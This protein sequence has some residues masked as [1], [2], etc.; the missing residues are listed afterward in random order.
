MS[1]NCQQGFPENACADDVFVKVKNFSPVECGQIP[2]PCPPQKLIKVPVKVAIV[3]VTEPLKDSIY[4]CGGFEEVKQIQRSVI[5]TQCHVTEK[6]LY[7]EGYITKNVGYVVPRVNKHKGCE[8][9]C[10]VIKNRYK[11]LTAKLDF[12]FTIPVKLEG[13]CNLYNYPVDEGSFFVDCMKQCDNGYCGELN[14]ERF[15]KQTV[16]LNEPFKYELEKYTIAESVILKKENCETK[17]SYDTIVE[18]LE[19]SLV[20]SIL[21]NQQIAINVATI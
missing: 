13:V 16:I 1:N 20:V 5:L 12:Y 10:K 15:Y 11:D 3:D 14:C 17:W 7:V 18:K 9:D 2:L 6:F 4:I 19:L 8:T 21:Q